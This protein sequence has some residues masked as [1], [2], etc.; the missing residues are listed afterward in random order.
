MHPSIMLCDEQQNPFKHFSF[1]VRT[2]LSFLGAGGMTMQE[3]EDV[4]QFPQE[5]GVREVGL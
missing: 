2:T 3:E 5:S 4:L 1:R